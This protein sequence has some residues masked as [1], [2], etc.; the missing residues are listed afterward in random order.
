LTHSSIISHLYSSF[1][2]YHELWEKKWEETQEFGAFVFL[3]ERE[4]DWE[5]WDLNRIRQYIQD[6]GLNDEDILD[7]VW[8]FEFGEEFLVLV[9]EYVDGPKSQNAYFH[10]MSKVRMN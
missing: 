3:P 10:R 4:L 2:L 7:P 5:W 1:S 9:I 6:G 8:D